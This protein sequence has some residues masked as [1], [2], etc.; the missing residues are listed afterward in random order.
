M[1][2]NTFQ[3]FIDKKRPNVW[4]WQNITYIIIKEAW[5]LYKDTALFS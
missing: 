5:Y 4:E 3:I 1:L 2:F